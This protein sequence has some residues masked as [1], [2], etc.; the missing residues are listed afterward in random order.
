MG[1]KIMHG[2]FLKQRNTALVIILT[3]RDINYE[4][5]SKE[6]KTTIYK[7]VLPNVYVVSVR[8]TLRMG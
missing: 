3:N 1:S 6:T 2:L 8:S 5:G 7:S 4:V